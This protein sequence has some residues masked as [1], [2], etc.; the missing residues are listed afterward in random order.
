MRI[1]K[2]LRPFPAS[3]PEPLLWVTLTGS[4]V[5]GGE[6]EWPNLELQRL[7][8]TIVIIAA[9]IAT[10]FHFLKIA[11]LEGLDRVWSIR[12]AAG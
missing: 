11:Q 4:G 2:I 9:V 3:D 5:G 12:G 7:W 8:P 10:G 6:I 1:A